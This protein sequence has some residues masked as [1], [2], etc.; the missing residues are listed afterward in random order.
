MLN[1]MGTWFQDVFYKKNVPSEAVGHYLINRDKTE[2]L[3]KF[4][5]AFPDSRVDEIVSEIEKAVDLIGRNVY[6]NLILMNL[7]LRIREYLHPKS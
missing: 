5:K 2:R 4:V 6:L 1:L 7:G 3:D